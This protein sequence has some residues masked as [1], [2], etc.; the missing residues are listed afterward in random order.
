MPDYTMDSTT[1]RLRT[2]GPMDSHDCPRFG[3]AHLRRNSPS[4]SI[5]SIARVA[6]SIKSMQF[7]EQILGP[8]LLAR[9]MAARAARAGSAPLQQEERRPLLDYNR[10]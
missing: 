7:K 9:V 5:W 2:A 8:R 3:C 6:G 1:M 4:K 10:M